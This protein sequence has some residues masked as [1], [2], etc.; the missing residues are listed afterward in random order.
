MK[1]ILVLLVC[2]LFNGCFLIGLDDKTGKFLEDVVNLEEFNSEYDDY[3]S[4][5]P[6]NRSG[7]THLTF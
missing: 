5:L 3:N 2:L 1:K 4:D 6:Y 7:H